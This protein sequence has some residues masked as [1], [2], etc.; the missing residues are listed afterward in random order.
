MAAAK[1]NVEI[2]PLVS[3]WLE[4]VKIPP[5][6]KKGITTGVSLADSKGKC[7]PEALQLLV[8][9]CSVPRSTAR[10][11]FQE[12]E[13]L[14]YLEPDKTYVPGK[15][16]YPNSGNAFKGLLFSKLEKPAGTANAIAEISS[17]LSPDDLSKKLTRLFFTD[18]LDSALAALCRFGN[19]SAIER[20]V[21]ALPKWKS[22]K[23]SSAP[24]R[25]DYYIAQCALLHSR[26]QAAM[27]YFDEE[28]DGSIYCYA[29]TNGLTIDEVREK[30]AL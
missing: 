10:D 8:S 15:S 7:S 27:R 12:Y 28:D 11:P 29:E 26:T 21:K 2:E 19:E 3:A 20:V 13:G 24:E 17:W 25:K 30:M 9:L 22:A 6:T 18:H 14:E 23:S 16:G 1:Q 5:K 4:E